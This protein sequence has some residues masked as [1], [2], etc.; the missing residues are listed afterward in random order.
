[1][2]ADCEATQQASPDA[3][4]ATSTTIDPLFMIQQ[5]AALNAANG[6]AGDRLQQCSDNQPAPTMQTEVERSLQEENDAFVVAAKTL[7]DLAADTERATFLQE[8]HLLDV[9]SL[10]L[11]SHERH[12]PRLTELCLGTVANMAAV[13]IVAQ[14]VGNDANLPTILLRVWMTCADAP[15]LSELARLFMGLA[16]LPVSNV[17]WHQ[18]LG[19]AQ[20]LNQ[21]LCL[22]M[23]ASE[24]LL[25]SRLSGLLLSLC[26]NRDIAYT[27]ADKQGPVP[28][29]PEILG[30]LVAQ[31]WQAQRKCG[32]SCAALS[33]P[34]GSTTSSSRLSFGSASLAG[35]FNRNAVKRR[36]NN[37]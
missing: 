17:T 31:E 25:L 16:T 6:P 23:N 13:P 15:T 19:A 14:A 35:T 2:S 7:W 37:I 20:P 10:I 33:T 12:R 18:I 8:H 36:L 21:L 9:I 32:G 4:G 24:P 22:A 34:W 30:H 11:L 29:F 3:S 5:I 1:M 28:H 26:H 27:L